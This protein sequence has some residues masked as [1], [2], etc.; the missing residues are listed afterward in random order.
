MLGIMPF[1]LEYR[2]LLKLAEAQT[3]GSVT[4][5][6]MGELGIAGRNPASNSWM[7]TPTSPSR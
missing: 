5:R 1:L 2:L 6:G 7:S 4:G 3:L